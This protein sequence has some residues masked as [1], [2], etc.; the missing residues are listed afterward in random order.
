MMR[1]DREN[2][3]TFSFGSPASV[4]KPYWTFY[5][6]VVDH[7]G[8]LERRCTLHWSCGLFGT[9]HPNNVIGA[10]ASECR[11]FSVNLVEE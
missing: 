11:V 6:G 8:L 4:Q 9:M 2:E 5:L 1:P 7:N 3:Q 10:M